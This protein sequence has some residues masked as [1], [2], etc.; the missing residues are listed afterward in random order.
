MYYCAPPSKN[1]GA[2]FYIALQEVGR[3]NSVLS[4]QVK[5]SL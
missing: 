3:N 2:E 1:F 5:W 4:V